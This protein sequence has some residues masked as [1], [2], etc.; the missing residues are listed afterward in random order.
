MGTKMFQLI[1][2]TIYSTHDASRPQVSR[3]FLVSLLMLNVIMAGPST[4]DTITIFD[5]TDLITFGST[6]P[7]RLQDPCN[8]CI[9]ISAGGF[10]NWT[11]LP[12]PSAIAPT[13]INDTFGPAIYM[14]E[15]NSN[16]V[17]DFLN[18]GNPIGASLVH[19]VFASDFSDTENGFPTE[20]TCASVG[21]CQIT[22]DGTVQT[23]GT[24][25]WSDGTVDTIRVQS[26][27]I[28]EPASIL[29]LLTGLGLLCM[30]RA[31]DVRERAIVRRNSKFIL[32]LQGGA[33]VVAARTG[34]RAA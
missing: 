12:P 10:I 19:G 34:D 29:L 31:S 18:I 8:P 15:R 20:I 22:E 13:V 30:A 9:E 7:S 25:T 3:V 4:A 33:V 14:Q 26:D 21:G 1:A 23:L 5:G 28:P 17:S 11:L 2:S 6:N 27:A 32:Q 24:I 16:L